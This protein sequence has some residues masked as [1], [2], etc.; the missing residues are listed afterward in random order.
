MRG[1][2]T[3]LGSVDILLKVLRAELPEVDPARLAAALEKAV[4]KA[5][6]ASLDTEGYA[7]VDLHLARVE[8]TEEATERAKILRELSDTLEQRGDLDRALVVRMAAFGEAAAAEDLDPLLRMA[9]VTDRWDEL[10][11]ETMSALIDIQDESA[12]ERLRAL[13]NAYQNVNKGYLAADCLERVLLLAP[14]DRAANEALELFYRSNT[15]WPVLIDLLGRRTVH[16]EDDRERAELFREIAQ[17]YERHLGDD[18]G[19]L[20]AYREADRL[21][22]DRLEVV[23]GLARLAEKCGV[24]DEETLGYLDRLSHV[25]VGPPARAKVLVK[26]ANIAALTDFDQAQML[27]EQARADDPDL[28]SAV[29]G[30]AK[31]LRDRGEERAAATLLE[32]AAVRPAFDRQ[33]SAWLADAADLCV[34]TGDTERAKQLYRGARE[35]DPNNHNAGVALVELCWDTGSLVELVPILDELCRTTEEPDRLRGY[36]IQR[37]KVAAQLGDATGVRRALTRAVDLDPKDARARRELADLLFE[38][39]SWAQARPLYES[40]LEDEDQ[41]DE[42]DRVELHFRLARCAR[43]LGDHETATKHAGAALALQPD[44]RG[45]LLLKAELDV[46]D[47]HALAAHQ[48]ALANLSPPEEKAQRFAALGDIYAD[49][50]NDRATAREMYREALAIRPH[51]HLLL[52]KYLELVAEEGDWSYS[53][54]LMQRLIDTEKDPKVRARFGHVAGTIARDHLGD[55]ELTAQLLEKAVEDDPSTF[56]AA[57]ELETLLGDDLEALVG[58]LYRRLEHVRHHEG[59]AGERLRLWDRLG[60]VCLELDRRDD[61]LTALEVALSLDQG[62]LERRARFADLLAASQTHDTDAIEQHQA[63]L[64]DAKRRTSSYQSLKSLYDRT[65]QIEKARAVAEALAVLKV[66]VLEEKPDDRVDELFDPGKRAAAV[67]PGA[68]RPLGNEDF[69]ALARLDVDLQLSALFALVAPQFAIERARIRPPQTLAAREPMLPASLAGTIAR[70]VT[71]FGVQQPA[72]FIDRDQ[73]ATCKLAMRTRNGVLAPV[74]VMGRPAVDNLIDEH[75]LAFSVARQLA[76][77][78]TDRIARLLCPRAGEL[79]Q[80]IELVVAPNDAG[81]G[82]ASKWLSAALHPLELEQTLQIGARL[83]ERGDVQPLSA[84]LS[85]LAST[86]RAADRIGFVVAGDLEACVRVLEREHATHGEHGRILELVWASITEE[87]LAVRN[88]VESWSRTTAARTA[89]TI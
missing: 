63:V 12:V 22:P 6:N 70:V 2:A 45:S 25:V 69:I 89:V 75:E 27:Y 26:A 81:R 58:F 46:E 86:D 73:L 40:L 21:D 10:P 83:R 61:A 53:L 57:D 11:L 77:L 4:A 68:S 79:S 55:L 32:E 16:V 59:R 14:A 24:P 28:A 36:L 9:R 37:S 30:F 48:L 18:S 38:K 56:N 47:P 88:R 60:E 17:I 78:R 3:D 7:V 64:R 74:L 84:A 62:N 54:D 20:D 23:E 71:A 72:V 35:A 33:R 85:W 8:A 34:A 44:H 51:D 39:L 43:E 13:A 5:A 80:I 41:F 50:L 67:A 52:T 49:K 15:E 66:H 1:H 19:A 29:E 87:L 76:D 31:L 82:G 65:G 42:P